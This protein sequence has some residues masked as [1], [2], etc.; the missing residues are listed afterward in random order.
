MQAGELPFTQNL[1]DFAL[2]LQ[3]ICSGLAIDL[4][5]EVIAVAFTFLTAMALCCIPMCYQA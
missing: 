5:K 4:L 1:R 2:D 3:L